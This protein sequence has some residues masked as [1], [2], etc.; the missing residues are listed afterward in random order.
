[1][2]KDLG[3][4]LFALLGVSAENYFKISGVWR[5]LNNYEKKIV[6]HHHNKMALNMYVFCEIS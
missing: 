2:K 1:M 3:I 5:E 6:K 4:E